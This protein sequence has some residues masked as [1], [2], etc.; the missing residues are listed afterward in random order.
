MLKLE[1]QRPEATTLGRTQSYRLIIQ[2]QILAEDLT[3]SSSSS[4]D[5]GQLLAALQDPAIFVI[6]TDDN[7][8]ESFERVVEPIELTTLPTAGPLRRTDRLDLWL[9]AGEELANELLEALVED[10][11]LLLSSL[12]LRQVRVSLD[13]AGV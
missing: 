3:Q 7:Q 6:T 4:A 12:A 13:G 2:A 8:V 11:R 5:D 9:P 1:I 10:V